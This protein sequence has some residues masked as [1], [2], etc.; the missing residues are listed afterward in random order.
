VPL[1]GFFGG[2]S[3]LVG[4]LIGLVFIVVVGWFD[5]TTGPQT[6]LA[7]LMLMP[8]LL[9]TWNGGRLLGLIVA[10]AATVAT[11]VADLA[12]GHALIP[13][14]NA[15]VWLSVFLLAVW[16][17]SALKAAI[18]KQEARMGRLLAAEAETS[19]DLREQNDLKDTLLHAVSHDLKGPLAGVLGAM[20]TI[21]RAEQLGLTDV[22]M[23]DLYGVIEQAGAKAAR[24]VDDLLDLDR[25]DRGQLKIEREATDVLGLARRAARE[26]PT[27]GGHP[28]RVDGPEVLADVDGPKVERIIDNLL[29]NAARHTAPGTPIQVEVRPEDDGLTVVV[30]DQGPGVPDPMKE[31]VFEAFRQGEAARGGVG[32]GLSLVR[33]FAELHGGS[34]RVEDRPGGGARFVVHVPGRVSPGASAPALRA[35]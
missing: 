20:Q 8:V 34:A 1:E 11:Q 23:E 22:E 12:D 17:L 6:S 29:G 27:L 28:V 10:G 21:R 13:S 24:L 30:E 25:L 26:L 15:F 19:T 7:P 35:V 2:A 18:T 33:R 5:H 9:A 3:P 16:L 32:I 14:W 31:A 4:L